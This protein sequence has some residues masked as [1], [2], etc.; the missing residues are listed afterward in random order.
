MTAFLAGYHRILINQIDG[1]LQIEGGCLE[2]K[3]FS[4]LHS[5]LLRSWWIAQVTELD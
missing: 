3:Q 1:W 5:S 2:S 4:E